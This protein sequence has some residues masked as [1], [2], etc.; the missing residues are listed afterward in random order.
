MEGYEYGSDV[1]SEEGLL[2]LLLRKLITGVNE[3]AAR[4]HRRPFQQCSRTRWCFIAWVVG[5]AVRSSQ[6]LSLE[7]RARRLLMN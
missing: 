7:G 5:E 2:W 3:E 4:A 6:A 1:I